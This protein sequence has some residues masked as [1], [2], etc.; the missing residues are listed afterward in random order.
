MAEV[1]MAYFQA[2]EQDL[3]RAQAAAQERGSQL[4]AALA[5]EAHLEQQVTALTGGFRI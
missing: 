1:D 4:Q 5:R 2:M 3:R